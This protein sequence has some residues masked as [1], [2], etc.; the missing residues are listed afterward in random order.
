MLA[1]NSSADAICLGHESSKCTLFWNDL[2]QQSV[3]QVAPA[4]VCKLTKSASGI[5]LVAHQSN[6]NA[7]PYIA[8]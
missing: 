6:M 7:V 5:N 1:A 2:V 8:A 3:Q 4:M